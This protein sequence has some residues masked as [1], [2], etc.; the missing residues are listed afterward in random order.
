M[1]P[2]LY[3]YQGVNSIINLDDSTFISF[4]MLSNKM[5]GVQFFYIPLICTEYGYN[6]IK[7]DCPEVI[8]SPSHILSERYSA[9]SNHS[10]I[11]PDHLRET[12]S[13]V[14]Q[15]VSK[16]AGIPDT[17]GGEQDWRGFHKLG[18]ALAIH[19]TIPDATLPIF[20]WEKNGWKPLI[21]R[22]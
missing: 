9:F 20:Y 16:R 1:P 6:R 12:A 22:R 19:D 5:R 8:L 4:R 11:W 14:I 7:N 18:L 2:L 13:H 10:I 15:S 21:Q 3:Y 17:N